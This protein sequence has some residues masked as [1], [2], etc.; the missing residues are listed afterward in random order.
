MHVK[1]KTNSFPGPNFG[2]G[3][4]ILILNVFPPRSYLIS[5]IIQNSIT[6][7]VGE[8]HRIQ[9]TV[10]SLR[11]LTTFYGILTLALVHR[12]TRYAFAVRRV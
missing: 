7:V 8:P 5:L 4:W 6:A 12:L 3:G 1:S 11:F 9:V 2:G 10:K